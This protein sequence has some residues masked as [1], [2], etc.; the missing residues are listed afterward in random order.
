M[1]VWSLC[2]HHLRIVYVSSLLCPLALQGLE[3]VQITSRLLRIVRAS[4]MC[5]LALSPWS[6]N[7]VC[8][9]ANVL[10]CRWLV[11]K[12][13]LCQGQLV[14][15]F[16]VPSCTCRQMPQMSLEGLNGERGVGFPLSSHVSLL[17][18]AWLFKG[19]M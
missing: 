10:I 15:A 8:V 9:F 12:S 6:Q 11:F 1:R 2:S 5:H 16:N 14:S 18:Q 17:A 7:T 3:S 4:C 13:A 19:D